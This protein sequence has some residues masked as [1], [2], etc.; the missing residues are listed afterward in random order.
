MTANQTTTRVNKIPSGLVHLRPSGQMLLHG[1]LDRFWSFRGFGRPESDLAR[2]GL[3]LG[4]RPLA[5]VA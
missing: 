3:L 2:E 5:K 4:N 1:C